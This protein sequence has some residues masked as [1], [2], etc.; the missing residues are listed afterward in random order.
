MAYSAA[1]LATM[2]HEDCGLSRVRALFLAMAA[3]RKLEAW[4][5]ATGIDIDG[6]TLEWTTPKDDGDGITLNFKCGE[7]LITV[8]LPFNLPSIL[9]RPAGETLQ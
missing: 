8:V 4:S 6:I 5:V 9:S 3:M 2:L 1:E 7:D